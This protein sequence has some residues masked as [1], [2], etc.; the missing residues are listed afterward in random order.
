MITIHLVGPAPA[1]TDTRLTR[2]LNHRVIYDRLSEELERARRYKHPLSVVLCD[3]D[4]FKEVKYSMRRPEEYGRKVSPGDLLV[5]ERLVTLT[6][7]RPSAEVP[8]GAT[9]AAT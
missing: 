5:H 8:V 6:H 9:P 3:F 1:D 4:H 2:Q 7:G